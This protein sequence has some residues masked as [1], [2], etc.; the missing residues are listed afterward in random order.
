MSLEIYTTINVTIEVIGCFILLILIFALFSNGDIKNKQ[1]RVFFVVLALTFICFFNEIIAWG[2][3]GK[4]GEN[5]RGI[6]IVTNFIA[7]ST[8]GMILI[9]YATY[10]YTCVAQRI[11]VGKHFLYLFI[12]LGLLYQ[13][14]ICISQFNGMI[15]RIDENNIYQLGPYYTG[16]LIYVTGV[17]LVIGYFILSYRKILGGKETMIL[18][19]YVVLPQ[20]AAIVHFVYVDLMV[21]Y[22]A[23][24]LSL[25]LTYV[26]FQAQQS[27]ELKLQ[28][29]DNRAMIMLSQ[30]QPHFL[31][32]SLTAIGDLCYSDAEKAHD[33][34]A[35]FANYLRVNM[36]SLTQ[37]ELVSFEKELEHTQKYLWLE[38]LRFGDRLQIIYDIQVKDFFLPVLTLQ[39]M[40][41]NAVRHGIIKGRRDGMIHIQTIEEEA[42][43]HIIVRDNGIGFDTEILKEDSGGHIGITNVRMR[44]AA[45][46]HGELIIKSVPLKGTLVLIKIPKV[47]V[48]YK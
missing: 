30:I 26:G 40:V 46:C 11:E 24:L 1:G 15:Y 37:K 5:A 4:S 21:M 12:G 42:F 10:I 36:N 14:V 41:E 44:L 31:F 22:V 8:T 3:D 23:N 35:T 27:K 9:A 32:N 39:P 20:F 19:S 33:A 18:L 48:E 38:Q 6:C 47:G 34:V 16:A 43:F 25:I 13:I 28:M 17:F 2:M 45:M 29:A 7:F